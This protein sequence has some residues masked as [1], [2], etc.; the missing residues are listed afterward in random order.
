MLVSLSVL[1]KTAKTSVV[2][3]PG[4]FLEQMMSN[5][6]QQYVICLVPTVF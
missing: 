1:W 5:L 3:C 4:I 2:A 6:L